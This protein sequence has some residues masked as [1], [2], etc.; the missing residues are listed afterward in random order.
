MCR[1]GV[2]SKTFTELT[3]KGLI[4]FCFSQQLYP[5]N[6]VNLLVNSVDLGA[7]QT[8]YSVTAHRFWCVAINYQA[9]SQYY[10]L[11]LFF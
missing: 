2:W 7:Y 10:F 9:L 3:G 4:C 5:D 6:P 1:Y 8:P 11:K